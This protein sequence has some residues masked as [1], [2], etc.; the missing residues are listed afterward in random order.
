M[1]TAPIVV[2]GGGLSGACVAWHLR[3]LGDRPVRVLERQSLAAETTAKSAGFVGFYG[4]ESG[5]ALALK[6]ASMETYN[7]LLRDPDASLEAF[8][9]GRL[10]LATTA[11]GAAALEAAAASLTAEA[12]TDAAVTRYVPGEELPGAML[13][14]EVA[15][16][17]VEGALY[18]PNIAVTRPQQLAY[19][20]IERARAAGATFAV[21]TT[22]EAVRVSEGRVA[23]VA[24]ADEVVETD[25]VVIAAGPWTPSLARTAGVD[26]PLS[27]SLGPVLR[28]E[29]SRPLRGSFPSLKHTESGL[30]LRQEPDGTVFVGQRPGSQ[31]ERDPDATSDAVPEEL[32]SEAASLV[33]ELVPALADATV[34]DEWVGV[35]TLTPDGTPVVGGTGVE[36]LAVLAYNANGV[37]TA[38][39]AGALVARGVLAGETP[40][41]YPGVSLGRFDG[42]ADAWL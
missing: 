35:R 10:E 29:P 27:H 7:E 32:V 33:P 23:G 22:V 21:N 3:R 9:S 38:P 16:A 39:G 42:Y 12:G 5:A 8:R 17:D 40:P 34:V 13:L 18:R 19:A 31:G 24:T 30:Y 15:L 2:V 1:S 26:L 25:A 41:Y 6:R 36:G 20:V 14:P 37:M 11:D 4:G 28:L